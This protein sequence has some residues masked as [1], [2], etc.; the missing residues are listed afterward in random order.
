MNPFL[1]SQKSHLNLMTFK[2]Y[3]RKSN[4]NSLQV[5]QLRIFSPLSW[6]VIIICLKYGLESVESPY[7]QLKTS[8]VPIFDTVL[9]TLFL[10]PS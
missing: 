8:S 1:R 2:K 9:K 10:M 3:Y 6:T 7:S 5:A 4:Q